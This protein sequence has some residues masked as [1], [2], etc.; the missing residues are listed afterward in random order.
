MANNFSIN[1]KRITELL[2]NYYHD[3][4]C[5]KVRNL[6]NHKTYF[7]ILKKK[8]DE[9]THSAFIAWL[10]EGRDFNQP[11]EDHPIMSFLDLLIA[12]TKI[13]KRG[14]KRFDNQ[15]K[16]AVLTRAI[17]INIKEVST[18]K[19][20]KDL[21]SI[22]DSKD[23]P[24]I[25]IECQTLIAGKEH[26]LQI[27]IENKIG[28]AEGGPKVLKESSGDE[29]NSSTKDYEHYCSL[30]QTK[31][32]YYAC[33]E[34]FEPKTDYA[35]AFQK[36]DF[37]LFVYLTPSD[38]IGPKDKNYIHIT[39]QDIYEWLVLPLRKETILNTTCHSLI[40]EYALTLTLPPADKLDRRQMLAVA[41]GEDEGAL[42][43]NFWIKHK[44]LVKSAA[45]C[46]AEMTPEKNPTRGPKTT[47]SKAKYLL[48]KFWGANS[49]VIMAACYFRLFDENITPDDFEEINYY[50][51]NLTP[52]WDKYQYRYKQQRNSPD[53][54]YSDPQYKRN[55][56]L[57]IVGILLN[58]KKK[59]DAIQPLKWH[60]NKENVHET[61]FIEEVSKLQQKYNNDPSELEKRYFSEP[62]QIN[63]VDYRLSNQWG[64]GFIFNAFIDKMTEFGFEIKQ[65]AVNGVVK[66]DDND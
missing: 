56:V 58:K 61:Y 52:G 9:N 12:K 22:E 41:I 23:R 14:N 47:E 17:D 46:Y 2:I 49:D 26:L 39:Y 59:L 27:I 51:S 15:L 11:K 44:E 57:E 42:L 30:T 13:D 21:S 50:L 4:N 35:K 65:V 38:A 24:D 10:L 31:R 62:F 8:Y 34:K 20:I 36:K 5:K 19:V 66:W 25:Y 48:E 45:D 33:S 43:E 54:I 32:Y 16:Q 64:S 40:K 53:Y 55:L 63:G 3:S 28:S 6:F 37:Q 18:E 1:E 29:A 60:D 7:D